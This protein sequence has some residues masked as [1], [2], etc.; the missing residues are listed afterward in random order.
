MC[1]I[2]SELANYKV[3]FQSA[4]RGVFSVVIGF[5]LFSAAVGCQ[6]AVQWPPLPGPRGRHAAEGQAAFQ[7]E[8]SPS[9]LLVRLRS[10]APCLAHGLFGQLLTVFTSCSLPL[11]N[12]SCWAPRSSLGCQHTVVLYVEWPCS[13][14]DCLAVFVLQQCLYFLL[15]QLPVITS[16]TIVRCRSCRTY[17]NPF[18][19][20][21]DQRRWK[22]NLCYRVNDGEFRL[23]KGS[24]SGSFLTSLSLP[25]ISFHDI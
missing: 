5:F 17:I 21:I 24:L 3:L 13:C 6:S 22:C 14:P 20:F 19:S 23:L 11:G 9:L 7:Q 2:F 15:Q 25:E 1:F 18:V 10:P 4:H 8:C 16:N 12:A